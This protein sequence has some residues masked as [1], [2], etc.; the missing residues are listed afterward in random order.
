MVASLL[1]NGHAS[2]IGLQST[3][4]SPLPIAYKITLH[5]IP[6][7]GFGKISGKNASPINP[8]AEHTSEATTQTRYPILSTNLA[9][10]RS[11][12]SYVKKKQVDIHAIFPSDI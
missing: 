11:I 6:A 9:Q 1:S 10:N 5:R 7:R 2:M 8:A 3:S 4:I 12:S